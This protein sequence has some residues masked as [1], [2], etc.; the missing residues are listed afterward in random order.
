MQ[1]GKEQKKDLHEVGLFYWLRE[2]DSIRIYKD[3]DLSAIEIV[4][5]EFNGRKKDL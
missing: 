3:D 1:L 5:N 4:V 2:H